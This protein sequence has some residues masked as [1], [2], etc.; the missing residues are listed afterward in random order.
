MKNI[1]Q[2]HSYFEYNHVFQVSL[3]QKPIGKY[4]NILGQLQV[5]GTCSTFFATYLGCTL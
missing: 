1:F 3:M 5:K 2:L 4:D